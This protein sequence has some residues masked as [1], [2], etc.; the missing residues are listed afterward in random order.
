M[1]TVAFFSC[2]PPPPRQAYP[3]GNFD[4]AQPASSDDGTVTLQYKNGGACPSGSGKAET[5][6]TF[7]CD[8][9]S[10]GLS[11]SFTKVE[12]DVGV[13]RY[14]ITWP[15]CHVCPGANPCHE[16]P[17]KPPGHSSTTPKSHHDGS[18]SSGTGTKKDSNKSSPGVVA[19]VIVVLVVVVVLG[20]FFMMKPERRARLMML[21]GKKNQPQFKY[22]K[23]QDINDVD[24]EAGRNLFD[25]DDTDDSD[26]DDT[27]LALQ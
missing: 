13:C 27:L 1:L 3:V 14:Q 7:V 22:Q 4:G 9:K 10:R 17:D 5:V 20:G 19:A 12:Q 2:P 26:D 24:A 23:M 15:S 21:F 18:D 8:R 25:D 16:A 6:I 11:P